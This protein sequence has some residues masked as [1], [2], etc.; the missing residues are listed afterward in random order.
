MYMTHQRTV[1]LFAVCCAE[2]PALGCI[3]HCFGVDL[4]EFIMDLGSNCSAP[5]RL[6]RQRL[7]RVFGLQGSSK[8]GREALERMGLHVKA[9]ATGRRVEG[10]VHASRLCQMRHS[11]MASKTS[12]AV[13]PGNILICVVGV[14]HAWFRSPN[15]QHCEPPLQRAARDKST[16]SQ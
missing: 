9:E 4:F 7:I 8:V 12:H 10:V 11:C 5:R 1:P 16:Q 6:L 3:I 2:G 13:G 15:M 14:A